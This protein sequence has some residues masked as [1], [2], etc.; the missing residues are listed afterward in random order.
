MAVLVG[1]RRA[2]RG[3]WRRRHL[4]RLR[5]RHLPYLGRVEARPALRV[6]VRRSLVRYA[7]GGHV[8]PHLQRRVSECASCARQYCSHRRLLLV[9][10]RLVR[11]RLGLGLTRVHH[12]LVREGAQLSVQ[13]ADVAGDL[14]TPA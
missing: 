10:L 11:Q 3:L 1:A 14:G 4:L 9:T 2:V 8:P 7:V 5:L 13:R 6:C 12:Q